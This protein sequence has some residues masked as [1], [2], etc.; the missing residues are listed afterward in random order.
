M[1]KSKEESYKEINNIGHTGPQSAV[2][3]V[4]LA[5]ID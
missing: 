4:L 2:I 3:V 5:I 1:R